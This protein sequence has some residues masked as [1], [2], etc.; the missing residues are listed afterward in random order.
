MKSANASHEI[1]SPE[2]HVSVPVTVPLIIVLAIWLP[3]LMPDGPMTFQGRYEQLQLGMTQE[4]VRAIMGRP[5]DHDLFPWRNVP[6]YAL[7]RERAEG[8]EERAEYQAPP[9][10]V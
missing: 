1:Q 10:K 6:T 4:R 3:A 9:W 8:K 5:G 2:R 7:V